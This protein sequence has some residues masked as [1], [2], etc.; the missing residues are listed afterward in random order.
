MPTHTGTVDHIRRDGASQ[1]AAAPDVMSVEEA[2]ATYGFETLKTEFI[3]EYNSHATL[4]RHIKTGAELM[5]LVNDDENKTFG[6]VFRTPP[7]N[8]T[9]ASSRTH[10]VVAALGCACFR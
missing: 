4:F 7:A 8:S 10:P 3:T 2:A 6:A 1:A 9:G 5:S